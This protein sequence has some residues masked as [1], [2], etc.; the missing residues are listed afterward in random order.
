MP[1][2]RR[3][4]ASTVKTE[5]GGTRR[6][7]GIFRE[8][9]THNVP[10]SVDALESLLYGDE[11]RLK[12]AL[13]FHTNVDIDEGLKITK[14]PQPRVGDPVEIL[15]EKMTTVV[16]RKKVEVVEE[17]DFLKK[18][19]KIKEWTSKSFGLPSQKAPPPKVTRV[20]M[21]KWVE[22]EVTQISVDKKTYTLR[23]AETGKLLAG[24]ARR[25]IRPL[26]RETPLREEPYLQFGGSREATIMPAARY[27]KSLRL[28]DEDTDGGG[29][30][31]RH[32]QLPT[33]DPT[34]LVGTVGD[35]LIHIIMKNAQL[36]N[37]QAVLDIFMGL[38]SFSEESLK[39][40]NESNRTAMEEM[41]PPFSLRVPSASYGFALQVRL[42]EVRLALGDKWN[43]SVERTK[44]PKYLADL[45]ATPESYDGALARFNTRG[46]LWEHDLSTGLRKNEGHGS[47]DFSPLYFVDGGRYRGYIVS[48]RILE[49]AQSYWEGGGGGVPEAAEAEEEALVARLH[50][51]YTPSC[52][53]DEPSR[54]APIPST[55]AC[56]L[57][58]AVLNGSRR[59]SRVPC[60][61]NARPKRARPPQAP[62]PSSGPRPRLR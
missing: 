42:R 10:W 41:D 19:K 50:F 60:G 17:D 11:K 32:L 57:S 27:F 59:R 1:K 7:Y 54:D 26:G 18:D 37:R 53:L 12:N 39:V 43:R 33:Y 25:R 62:P 58:L 52:E 47:S 40:V 22:C 15:V 36:K 6:A 3:K 16:E 34:L 30:Y 51:W 20:M 5:S 24:I 13:K 46:V 38:G 48:H 29:V 8:R 28:A 56:A 31:G 61:S 2:K 35:T 14:E 23:E 44:I 49:A 55:R 4:A 21:S 45:K 9:V